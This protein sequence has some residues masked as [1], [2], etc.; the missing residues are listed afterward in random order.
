MLGVSATTP[1]NILV[2][3]DDADLRRM[4]R[5]ALTLAGFEVEEAADGLDAL[6]RIE[7][8]RPDLLVLDLGLPTLSGVVVRQEIAA[9]A[10]TRHI[11]VVV[12]TGRAERLDYLDVACVLRKPIEPDDL[13]RSVKSCLAAGAPGLS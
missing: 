2:V 3:E 5:T 8:R 11:P 6:K 1:E 7:L 9:H 10:Y 12:V 13:V 4:F